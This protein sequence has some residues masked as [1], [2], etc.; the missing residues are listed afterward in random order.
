ML[1][2][3]IELKHIHFPFFSH[4]LN[5]AYNRRRQCDFSPLQTSNRRCHQPEDERM[6]TKQNWKIAF[7]YVFL[8]I[9]LKRAFYTIS[10]FVCGVNK[11]TKRFFMAV[12]ED[13][14]LGTHTQF[15]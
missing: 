13:V 6:T 9:Y 15:V 10:N 8:Q 12:N 4:I 3:I 7:L 5:G 2:I 11:E 14:T 1:F